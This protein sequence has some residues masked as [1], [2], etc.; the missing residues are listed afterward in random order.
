MKWIAQNPASVWG[1]IEQVAQEMDR[2]FG[3]AAARS[4][5]PSCEASIPMQVAH[6]D[7]GLEIVAEV[8][9]VSP[10]RIEVSV[11]GRIL[12]LRVKEVEKAVSSEEEQAV[13]DAACDD[14]RYG[15]GRLRRVQLPANIDGDAVKASLKY[16]VLKLA[17]P[18]VKK[19]EPTRVDVTL[20][21]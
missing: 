18:R 1:P 11:D 20:E 16:G 12:E 17:L 7:T 9:G 21:E 2:W 8:P 6:G 5:N 10:D 14:D 15:Q 4:T 3:P 19:P 13:S